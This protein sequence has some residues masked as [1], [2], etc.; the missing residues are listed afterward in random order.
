MPRLFV[1]VEIPE[2]SRRAIADALAPWRADRS[3][4]WARTDTWH[5]TLKFLGDTDDSVVPALIGA[6]R[7]AVEPFAPVP[8]ALGGFGAFP[9]HGRPRVLW[10]GVGGDVPA[11]AAIARAVDEVAGALG[12][13]AEGRPYTPHLT[14]GR[15]REDARGVLG[16]I[17][18]LPSMGAFVVDRVVLFRSELAPDGARHTPLA[19]FL[20][21]G[22]PVGAQI[23]S[24]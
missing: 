11:L 15:A 9:P 23:P 10:V 20:L 8:V 13:P 4:R 6:L 18:A 24:G 16:A 22:S 12:F 7:A 2:A 21:A 1:A 5:L 17:G 3:V 14:V 19:T